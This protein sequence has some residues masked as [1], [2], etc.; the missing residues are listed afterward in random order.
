M[1]ESSSGQEKTQQPTAK[2]LQ[3]ARDK[4][5]VPRS[6]ELATMTLVFGGA[7]A[8]LFVGP[9]SLARLAEMFRAGFRFER[10]LAMH[11]DGPALQLARLTGDGFLAIAPICGLL[12]VIAAFTPLLIGGFSFSTTA[13]APDFSRLSP[14]K[15]LGRIFGPNGLMEFLKALAKFLFVGAAATVL[16]MLQMDDLLSLL[17]LDLVGAMGRVAFLCIAMLLSLGAVLALIAA[18]DVP[19]QLWNHAKGLRMTLQEVRDEM[20]ETEGRPE[21]KAR[22]RQVQ[23]EMSRRRMMDAIP[24]ADVVITNPTHYAVALRYGRRD[25]APRVV[26]KGV[27]LLATAIRAKAAEHDVPL[28]EAPPLARALYAST[29]LDAEIPPVLFV[30]VAQ[31]LAYVY[32]LRSPRAGNPT[33][34][35]PSRIPVPDGLDPEGP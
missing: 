4:G 8:L 18:I 19:F 20:K 6:R 21:V 30:A 13:L 3:D 16:F 14:I 23:R 11:E 34:R 31:V 12:M 10:E 28:F 26:A 17:R 29:R 5:Q 33:P 25:G 22:V 9:W 15:G 35:P 7:L 27:D 32:Q 1:S 24:T 2:R